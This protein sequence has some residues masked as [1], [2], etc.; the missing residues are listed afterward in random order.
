MYRTEFGQVWAMLETG[1]M[2]VRR[3]SESDCHDLGQDWGVEIQ[4]LIP[5][6]APHRGHEVVRLA[7][8]RLA[9]PLHAA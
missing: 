9:R 6:S 7:R 3:E 1:G 8:L 4:G 5:A 2:E